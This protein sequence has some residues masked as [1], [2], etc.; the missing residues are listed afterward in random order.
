M[1][2]RVEEAAR[3]RL[4]CCVFLEG[5]C[6]LTDGYARVCQG[7]VPLAD[8]KTARYPGRPAQR[9]DMT[10]EMMREHVCRRE[11]E[12]LA[13]TMDGLLKQI[14]DTLS[15]LRS[16][17]SGGSRALSENV[18]KAVR[19]VDELAEAAQVCLRGVSGCA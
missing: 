7:M 11:R 15:D 3:G 14:S 10:C 19:H 9:F 12:A 5:G 8:L 17:V 18:D 13:E 4:C 1:R 2:A 16:R 6:D